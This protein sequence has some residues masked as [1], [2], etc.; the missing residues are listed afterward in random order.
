MPVKDHW[1]NVYNSKRATEVSW[2]QPHAEVSLKLILAAELPAGVNIIDVG[3]GAS[4]L[5]DDLLDHGYQHLTVLDLS[6]AA[7]A[8]AKAR[9]GDKAAEVNWLEANVLEAGFPQQAFDVWHDRA[10]FHFLTEEKDRQR[11]VQQVLQAVKPGG[12]VI[13]ATFA[14]DGPEQCSGLP[15]VRYEAGQLHGEFGG[16]FRLLGHEKERHQTPAGFEQ[17]FIYCFCKRLAT[18]E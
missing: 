17:K 9:L 1:E 4:M 11:Y 3:G 5:V 18:A 10:V 6:G 7:L 8:T 13:V 2:F 16:S 15:V 14:E 12:L